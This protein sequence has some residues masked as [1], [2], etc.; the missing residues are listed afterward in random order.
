MSVS[1]RVDLD[2]PILTVGARSGLLW[3]RK[4]TQIAGI[5]QAASITLGRP[6][7][8]S[9]AMAKLQSVSSLNEVGLPGSGPLAFAALDFD[10]ES[11][12]CLILP[13]IVLAVGPN[14]ER[15]V[16][17]NGG[18]NS[19]FAPTLAALAAGQQRPLTVDERTSLIEQ[20]EV[21]IGRTI[22]SYEGSRAESPTEFGLQSVLPPETWRDQVVDVARQRI[23]SGDLDK[24]VLARELRLI[25]D[26]PVDQAAV[27]ERLAETYPT[28]A[29]FAVD[30]FVGASPELL[31]SRRGDVVRAHPLAG[32]APRGS[33]PQV[34][35]SLAAG[36]LASSKDRWEHQITISWL[37]DNLLPFCSYVDA[38]PEP[39]I[40][41]L[42]NVHHLGTKVEGRLS[43]P[44]APVLELVAALHPTP[45]VGGDPQ[46]EALALLSEIEQADRG[47]YA[48]P[49]GWL[50]AEGNGEFAVAIRSAQFGGES[51]R[52]FAG[53]GVV[54][55]SDPQAELDETRSKFRA[56]LGA[57]IRP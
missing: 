50:D 1:V 27:I 3:R 14:G 21:I 2:L 39:T 17:I 10:P 9:D 48:G 45:A 15:W 57:L 44:A 52:I 43:Q 31:V 23:K 56:I 22:N 32:T 34:D 49:T 55:D 41:S 5:G 54:A 36:L 8:F 7:G 16:T 20:V 6:Q 38:E 25:T 11:D 37:L 4:D 24:A 12:G 40:V 18:A 35:Q 42:A 26:Q 28:A 33:D 13:E 53:V 19:S 30:G 51:I 46:K 29:L 47:R